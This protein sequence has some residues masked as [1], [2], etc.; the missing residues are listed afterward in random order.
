MMRVGLTG[1]IGSGK[2][3]VAAIFEEMGIPVFYAD[4]EAKQLYHE[5]DVRSE[6]ITLLGEDAYDQE[7]LNKTYVANR[8]FKDE[9]L[10]NKLNAIIHPRVG[11]QWEQWCVNHSHAPYIIKEA[12]IMIEAGA[13]K[14]LDRIVVV[15]APE[16]VRIERVMKR[17]GTDREEVEQRVQNQ[18]SQEQRREYA[19]D[20]INNDGTASLIHQV[21]DLHNRFL[22]LINRA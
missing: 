21:R 18:W 6:V 9:A 8:V 20:I 11:E 10:L 3:T 16:E 19:S 17:D 12:A 2:S 5:P 13:H 14:D 22:A 4:D 15:E 7:H 1:G